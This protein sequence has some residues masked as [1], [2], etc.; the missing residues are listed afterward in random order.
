MTITNGV[1]QENQLPS[2]G[3]PSEDNGGSST[4]EAETMF[5]TG[6]WLREGR[7]R[8]IQTLITEVGI[9]AINN[10]QN[11]MRKYLLA[12]RIDVDK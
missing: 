2:V 8:G 12:R 6:G 5:N 1:S 11:K 9:F 4:I 7:G 3:A 10:D